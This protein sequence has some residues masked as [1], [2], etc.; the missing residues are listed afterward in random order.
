MFEILLF[1]YH[2]LYDFMVS[3]FCGNITLLQKYI[4][5]ENNIKYFKSSQ[6]S[7]LVIII[8]HFSNLF[9]YVFRYLFYQFYKL[10]CVLEMEIEIFFSFLSSLAGLYSFR[11]IKIGLLYLFRCISTN[12]FIKCITPD[13]FGSYLCSQW[14]CGTLQCHMCVYNKY[15]V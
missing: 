2:I 8:D 1:I 11:I 3:I 12:G 14:V 9:G 7:V 10:A 4:K 15:F 5:I 13:E 6:L